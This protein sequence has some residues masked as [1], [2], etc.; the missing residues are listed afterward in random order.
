MI[1][2]RILTTAAALGTLAASL[3]GATTAASAAGVG[4]YFGIPGVYGSPPPQDRDCWKWSHRTHSWE[5][6][7]SRQHPDVTW[8]HDHRHWNG[9]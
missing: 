7:C 8:D 5:W 9:Y 3:A 2:K 4:I 6:R 1:A